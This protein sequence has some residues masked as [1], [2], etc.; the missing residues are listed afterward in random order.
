MKSIQER[1]A[2]R[3]QGKAPSP[4]RELVPL[5]KLPGMISLGG[6]YPNPDTFVFSRVE[7]GFKQGAKIV[8]EG[9]EL[10]AASQYGPTDG[11]PELVQSLLEWHQKKDGVK[12]EPS[13]ILVLNGSQE[14]LFIMPYL[15]LDEDDTCVVS[16]PD[17]SGA[18]GAFASFC[19]TTPLSVPLDGQG[20]DTGALAKLLAARRQAGQRMPKYVYVVPNGHNPGGVALSLD[21][22]KELVRLAEEHDLLVLEDDPYQ[23][24]RLDGSQPPPTLQS[25][26]P[27]RVIRLDSFS[28]IFTPGLRVGYVTGPADAVRQFVLF[29]QSCNLHTSAL[30]QALLDKFLRTVGPEGFR[31]EIR[32]N[33]EFYRTNRDA[34]VAAAR[35]S[36]PKEVRFNVPT[37]GMFIWFELPARCDAKRMIEAD[38]RKE[39]VIAVPGGA[40]STTGGLKNCL[41]A[42]YSLVTPEQIR[43][44]MKRLGRM[45]DAELK[46]G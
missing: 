26:A 11:Q 46:R 17:Y 43:E 18:L 2:R 35:E 22:R 14:G 28:K 7:V 6:G 12:L 37:E 33:C 30:A 16:E 4:I 13:Q 15:F 42:S 20:M 24:V 45:I 40:F 10:I 39:L 21:R 23:L 8:L 9:K 27:H 36:L 44:G 25:M 3:A 34:M 41:R 32:K 29:K 1:L 19:K 38:T 31:A 5:M